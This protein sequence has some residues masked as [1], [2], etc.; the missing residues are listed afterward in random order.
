[1]ERVPSTLNN[2]SESLQAIANIMQPACVWVFTAE[3]AWDGEYADIIAKAFLSEHAAVKYMHDFL[4]D[5]GGDESIRDYVKR[6]EWMTEVDDPMLFRSS[7]Q[8]CYDTDHIDLTI[9]KCE[10]KK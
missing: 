6:K 3:Q 1:M 4:L 2:I 8:G 5:D 10:I 7:K 9:T